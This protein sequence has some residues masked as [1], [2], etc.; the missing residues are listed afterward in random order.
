MVLY[1]NIAD[2]FGLM[3]LKVPFFRKRTDE[4]EE[5]EK[6]M[7]E[8]DMS[9]EAYLSQLNVIQKFDTTAALESLS[10]QERGLGGLTGDKILVLAGKTDIL[11]PVVLSK[12]LAEKVQGTFLTVKGGHAC[13]WE[14]PDDFNKT[15]LKFLDEHK[16]SR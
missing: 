2:Y 7:S 9:T 1:S 8:L 4:L 16:E 6:A 10:I 12:E 3:L 11:I 14:F 15:V 13:M 5:V